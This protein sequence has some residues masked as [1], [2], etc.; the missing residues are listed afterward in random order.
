MNKIKFF[1]IV[2]FVTIGFQQTYAQ[3]YKFKTSGFSILQKNER[4][5]W[6]NWSDLTLV[7]I[8]VN[9]D[10]NKNRFVIYLPLVQLFEIEVYEPIEENESDIVYAFACKDANGENCV[11]SIITRKKQ[12]N[13]K[14]LYITYTNKIIVYN[15]VNA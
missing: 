15:I 11:I 10:T 6:G 12:D 7:N 14:Q 5:K 13:R 9:L 8:S 2:F 4:G 3:N 1:I